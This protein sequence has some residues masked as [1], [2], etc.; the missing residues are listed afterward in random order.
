LLQSFKQLKSHSQLITLHSFKF[1]TTLMKKGLTLIFL[2]TCFCFASFAQITLLG[3]FNP[4]GA[5]S[6]C[7]IGYDPATS[8]VW[9][10]G[11]SA[12]TIQSYSASGTLLTSVTAPGGTANDVDVEMAP[13]ELTINSSTV[14][15]GQ[16]LFVNGESNAAEI[17]AVNNVSGAI[18]ATLN[19]AFGSSHVVGGSYHP[20]RNTFFMVQDNV[21]SSTLENLIAEVDPITG[22]V[23]Q[24]FQITSVFNVS[25]GDVEVGANGN[26]FVVSSIEDSIAEFTPLGALVKMHAL[27]A[28]VSTLSGIAIDCAAGEAWVSSTSGNV[29]HLGQFPGSALTAAISAG[30]AT[31]FCKGSSVILSVTSVGGLTYAWKKGSNLIAGATN[32]TYEATTTADYSC[33]VSN[34]CKSVTSNKIHVTANPKPTVDFTEAACSA[35]AVLL[36]RTGTPTSG[37][38]YKWKLNNANIAGATNATYPATV[39][40][41]YKVEVTITATGCK[42]SSTAKNVTVNCKVAASGNNFHAEA[43][44]NPFVNSITVSFAANSTTRVHLLLTDLSGRTIGEYQNIDPSSPFEINEK[45][46]PGVYFLRVKQNNQEQLIKIVKE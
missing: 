29:Y 10:Y 38:T 27:P 2:C 13:E 1:K 15:A 26:L 9:I 44:P 23:L 16:L 42:K 12:S 21:P 18:V 25:Y 34:A 7:G 8:Q 5:S 22:M 33:V 17:Y 31:T 11:C 32:P 24:T 14:P 45:L 37:V 28:G 6:L 35:G 39:S 30:G 40:G 43:Y 3:S 19:T 36:T 41:S 20:V 46:S 4:S